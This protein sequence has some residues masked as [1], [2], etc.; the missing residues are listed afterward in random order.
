MK[1][2]IIT[3]EFCNKADFEGAFVIYGDINSCDIGVCRECA[4]H[5][6]DYKKR[7]EQRLEKLIKK[8][9]DTKMKKN[10]SY[11]NLIK[12]IVELEND[13]SEEE[14]RIA[15]LDDTD[16]RDVELEHLQPAYGLVH[17]HYLML[18]YM[19]F[20]QE[21]IDFDVAHF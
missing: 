8:M 16:E 13:I 3:C 9:E 19:G 17:E 1:K 6:P 10:E 12:S 2:R 14:K 15:L 5:N 20:T 21:Q 11:W 7:H 18:L 4:L